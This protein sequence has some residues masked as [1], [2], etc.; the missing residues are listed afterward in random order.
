MNSREIE[1][2]ALSTEKIADSPNFSTSLTPI[3]HSLLGCEPRESL[4]FF[5]NGG[6]S[7]D[8]VLCSNLLRLPLGYVDRF[9]MILKTSSIR[10]IRAELLK[11]EEQS[12]IESRKTVYKLNEINQHNLKESAEL[13]SEQLTIDDENELK[14]RGRQ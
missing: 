10:S 2:E 13:L 12:G 7:I 9:L 1:H 4:T 3:L 6:D 14:L 5:E 11:V 8:A